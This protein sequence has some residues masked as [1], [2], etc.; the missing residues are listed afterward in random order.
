M[1]I[2]YIVDTDLAPTTQYTLQCEGCDWLDIFQVFAHTSVADVVVEAREHGWM[3][4]DTG[5]GMR[6]YCAD[7]AAL[8]RENAYGVK[9]GTIR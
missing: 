9:K 7:C 4:I 1:R 5:S 6:T 2:N 8:V 3:R